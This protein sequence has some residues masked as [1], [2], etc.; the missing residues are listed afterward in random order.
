MTTAALEKS[1]DGMSVAK[2]SEMIMCYQVRPEQNNREC[3]SCC[4][5]TAFL[6]W[7]L[8]DV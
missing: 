7:I 5:S 3:N 6:H 1:F 2:V 8:R 4:K